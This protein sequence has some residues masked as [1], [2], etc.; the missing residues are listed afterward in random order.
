MTTT[1]RLSLG[2]AVC[3]STTPPRRHLYEPSTN[4]AL[5]RI[6]FDEREEPAAR[7]GAVVHSCLF[8]VGSRALMTQTGEICLGGLLDGGIG[9]RQQENQGDNAAIEKKS[10]G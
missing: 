7:G 6:S 9:I 3:E 2:K 5:P 8:S 10:H 1:P 4:D